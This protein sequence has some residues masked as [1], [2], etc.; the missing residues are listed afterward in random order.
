[1]KLYRNESCVCIRNV[2]NRTLSLFTSRQHKK[3][4]N[5]QNNRESSFSG[6]ITSVKHYLDRKIITI[7]FISG[8]FEKRVIRCPIISDNKLS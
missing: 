7:Y 8:Q 1:M 2:E 5:C 6:K 3:I 4:Q